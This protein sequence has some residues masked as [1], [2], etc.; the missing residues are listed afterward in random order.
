MPFVGFNFSR[1][2]FPGQLFQGSPAHVLKQTAKHT[3]SQQLEYNS[4]IIHESAW[5]IGRATA[6]SAT[7]SPGGKLLAYDLAGDV[8]RGSI[9]R[10]VMPP[11][12]YP[13]CSIVKG[14]APNMLTE[15]SLRDPVL[16]NTIGHTAGLLLFGFIITLFLRDRR[17]HGVRQTKLSIGAATLALGWNVGSLIA[18]GVGGSGSFLM[19]L[20]MA[21]A[22]SVLSLL[23]AVL[24]QIAL[25]RQLPAI[26]RAGYAVS[27]LA[28]VLHVSELSVK[29]SIPH[30]AALLL[31]AVGFAILTALA[32]LIKRRARPPSPVAS[33]EWFSLVCL[34]LFTSSFPHFGYQHLRSPWA[35]EIAWHHIG[36]PVAIIVLL[37]DYRFLLLDTFIRFL[38]N[39]GLAAAYVAAI[40][41]LNQRFHLGKLIESSAFVAGLAL[42][43]VCL[44]LILF[45]HIRNL[46]QRW[47]GRAIF[48]RQNL[49]ERLRGISQLPGNARSED[50]LLGMAARAMAAHLR[51]DR[52]AVVSDWGAAKQTDQPVMLFGGPSDPHLPPKF[53]WAEA[54]VPLRFSS[55]EM[56]FLLTGARRG[57]Q[58]YLS[59]DLEDMRRLGSAI[60]EQVERFR[61]EELKRLAAQAE[62]RALQAQINPHFL[63]NALNTLYGTID[64]G[65]VEARRL[66][67]NL[68]DIFRYFLQGDRSF[69]SL[70]EELRIVKAYLEIEALRLGDRLETE[71]D[72]GESALA[73]LIPIL[74]IQ[75]L[76]ENA[77]KHG[78]AAKPDR[79][80]VVVRAHNKNGVLRVTVEDTGGGFAGRALSSD[81]GAGVGL[82]NVRRRLNLSYGPES[83]LDVSSSNM[84]S[85]V[86]FAIPSTLLS[87]TSEPEMAVSS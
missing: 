23:P 51:T 4:L 52:F 25:Q 20:V 19:A 66:V 22:F 35:A 53:S 68:S 62:L 64:R 47:I 32:F 14:T 40:L 38:V 39:S 58:R 9:H 82:A 70:A 42:V 6:V 81:D 69:I 67:L 57:R 27:A 79:G 61:S 8:A 46:L 87:T 24:L 65:S 11:P 7:L 74:S 34:V 1:G 54:Q 45:A 75:P 18:L 78:V 31:V 63:F 28:I 44:S 26:A 73:V 37:R 85:S 13:R 12:G 60:V 5:K 41:L 21:A 16:I 86:T 30:Q 83:T 2:A 15:S 55:G 29:G 59:E 56:K 72:V 49:D 33:T 3:N 48:R 10:W 76:V 17:A 71:L 80:R 77:V 43:G 36:I 50:E 84:G